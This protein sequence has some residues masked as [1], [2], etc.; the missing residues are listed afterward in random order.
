MRTIISEIVKRY[1]KENSKE[2]VH[3]LRVII[4]D[5]TRVAKN[6][7]FIC[8]TSVIDSK[9]YVVTYEGESMIV[10]VEEYERLNSKTYNL[11]G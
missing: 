3:N 2:K 9:Y 4:I 10:T 7:K 8:T 6:H 11:N 1:I 5:S